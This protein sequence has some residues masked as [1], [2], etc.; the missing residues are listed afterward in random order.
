[1]KKILYLVAEDSYFCSHRL[2][3]AVFMQ[4]EGYT[5]AVATRCSK[6]SSKDKDDILKQGLQ[7][8]ELQFFCRASCINP[9]KELLAFK[10]L[11][12]IYKTFK[13]DLVHHVALKPVIY[14]TIVARLVKINKIVNALAGLG[15]VFTEFTYK[16][17]SNVL[18]NFWGN[19]K[20]ITK[21]KVLQFFVYKILKLII[22]NNPQQNKILLMQNKDDLDI[23]KKSIRVSDDVELKVAIVPGSGINMDKYSNSQP[24]SNINFNNNI[25]IILISR[26]LWTKGIN[27]F[28][29]AA[30]YIKEYIKKNNLYINP[31]FILYGD[32]DSKN[33]ASVRYSDLTEWQNQGLVVWKNFCYD[34]VAAYRDCHIAVLPSYR[35][36]LP[37]SLLEAAACARAIV[38][39][40]VPG[41][42]EIVTDG[43]NGYLVPKQNSEML[44]GA[45]LKL[46]QNQES[47]IN[48]GILGRQ[49]VCD[50]FSNQVIFPQI[51]GVYSL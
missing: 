29:H 50:K 5:V 47:M 38:T 17:N 39:T 12:N 22:I 24:L 25:K 32:I 1:M 45:L 36:G 35:E 44:A 3:L 8:F 20:K 6:H 33:P 42:R 43:V 7:L 37:K 40:D 51:L 30:Q 13:P 31:E 10:E 4:Q 19:I 48:M 41:C 15:F 21:Q 27:E 28:I 26:L 9:F 14:G 2:G 46:M 49:K 23:L 16:F 34:V 11:Y 18:V